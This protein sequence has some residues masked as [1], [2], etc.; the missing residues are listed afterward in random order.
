MTP[1]QNDKT[2]AFSIDK[3][4]LVPIGLLVSIVLL[5]TAGTWQLSSVLGSFQREQFSRDQEFALKFQRIEMSLQQ[6]QDTVASTVTDRWRRHE[7][8]EWANLLKANNPS[9]NVPEVP[10]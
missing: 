4:T 3:S 2:P 9:L 7:M 6:L 5:V 10:R 1:S 8:R